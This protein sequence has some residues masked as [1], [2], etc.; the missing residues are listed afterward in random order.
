MLSIDLG[1]PVAFHRQLTDQIVFSILTGSYC[2]GDKLPKVNELACRLRINPGIVSD[3]YTH[4]V[5]VGIVE[6]DD[7]GFP[8]V[9]KSPDPADISG[10]GAMESSCLD[11]IRAAQR[12]GLTFSEVCLFFKKVLDSQYSM[13][14]E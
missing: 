6:F 12:A 7:Q 11:F 14:N 8:L 5:N 9:V 10:A 4:L 3:A 2:M 13:K 1:S